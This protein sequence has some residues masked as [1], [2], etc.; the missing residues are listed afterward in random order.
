MLKP[1]ESGPPSSNPGSAS[2]RI[3]PVFS[4]DEIARRVGEI[5]GEIRKDAGDGEVFLLCILK[6]SSIF[7]ADLLRSLPGEVSYGF[8]DVVRD[9]GD[10][11]I[12]DALEIDF[13]SFTDIRDRNV[14]VL[15]DVVNTGVIENYLLTQLRT[16]GPAALRL[17]A[18]LD[19]PDVRTVDVSADFSAFTIH[20]GTYAG[21]GLEHGRRFAN[22]P[23]IG[24]VGLQ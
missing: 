6:G 15:K 24:R 5:A 20:E 17:V 4:A 10:N 19:R 18:L 21:Y 12:A 16:H 9:A 2:V 23:F 11:Q 22:L 7:L 13:L 1:E 8:I 3:V 14:Y